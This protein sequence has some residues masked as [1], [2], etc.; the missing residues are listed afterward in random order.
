MNGP[1]LS[2]RSFVRHGLLL[3][4]CLVVLALLA[5]RVL[6]IYSID[7]ARRDG[8]S[9]LKMLSEFL[10]IDPEGPRIRT[11]GADQWFGR[12]RRQG[13]AGYIR[14]LDPD[15]VPVMPRADGNLP[16]EDTEL[17]QAR[18]EGTGDRLVRREPATLYLARAIHRDDRLV[19]FLHAAMPLR[20]IE[21]DRARAA[22]GITVALLL[23]AGVGSLVLFLLG[24]REARPIEELAAHTAALADGHYERSAPA[25]ETAEMGRISENLDRL[26][27]DLMSRVKSGTRGQNNLETILASMVEGLVA[28]DT[29]HR[30]ILVNERAK[31]L[32]GADLDLSRSRLLSE[33]TRSAELHDGVNEAIRDNRNVLKEIRPA[34]SQKILA[35]HI[36]PL[37]DG[38][39]KVQGAVCVLHDMTTIRRLENMR[40]DFVA[41]VSHEIKTPLTAIQGAAETILDDEAMA[42]ETRTRF[43]ERI[44]E[45]ARRLNSLIN[46]VLELSRVQSSVDTKA[47]EPLDLAVIVRESVAQLVEPAA[48][49][50]VRLITDT[51]TDRIRIRGDRRSLRSVIDNL[52]TNAINYTRSDGEVRVTVS[53]DDKEAVLVVADTGI[54][55]ARE[56]QQRI[57]ERFYR[58]DGA[59]SRSQGGTGLGLAI[60]K[61]C[62]QAHRG[63][64]SVASELG[65][66]STF[67]VRFPLID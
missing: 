17:E 36:A 4:L 66:G 60:V 20:E 62:V 52:V 57:F 18:K 33:L 7:A 65:K 2:V 47:H 63:T 44:L 6:E 9:R 38:D 8:L 16:I 28:V 10:D 31:E 46:D 22:G 30:V 1:R 34:G 41:N 64:I 12:Q 54:G 5:N 53:A 56:Q 45:N 48:R 26:G 35:V 29:K 50:A 61:N 40:R 24:R 15:G 25:W 37:R 14:L 19:G 59:R 13:V 32:L 58:V 27:D 21:E 43:V 67:T 39:R 49:K 3:L 11:S 55:I 42:A 23:V 51:G